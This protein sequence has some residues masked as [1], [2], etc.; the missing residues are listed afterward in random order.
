MHWN[1]HKYRNCDVLQLLRNGY[2]YIFYFRLLEKKFEFLH[3]QGFIF[4]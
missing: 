3:F 4:T 2:S 1:L